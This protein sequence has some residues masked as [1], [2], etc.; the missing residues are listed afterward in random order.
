VPFS[1]IRNI[2]IQSKEKPEYRNFMPVF[3]LTSIAANLLFA[4]L[5]LCFENAFAL[6]D[7][8]G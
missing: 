6:K 3:S 7:G 2:V 1:P 5:S 4:T 8:Q